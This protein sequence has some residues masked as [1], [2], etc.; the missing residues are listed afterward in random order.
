MTTQHTITPDDLYLFNEGTHA[1]LGN[2]LGA[3][4]AT[5]NG[6]EGVHFAVWAPSACEVHLVGDFNNWD[7]TATPMTPC[8]ASGI[9]EAFVPGLDQG[10]TYKYL[11][12][13][14]LA[15]HEALKADPVGIHTETPP[16]SA[17]KVWTPA[18]QWQDSDWLAARDDDNWHRKPMSI[19]EVHLGSWR[20][21]PEQDNRSLSYRELA[22]QLTEY[23]SW[24]GFTHVELMPIMEHPFD[25]S[26]GYQTTG[27]FAP[28]SRFGSPD[29]FA[30]LVD[31][32]HQAGIGVILD[33]VPSH[34]ATDGHGLS[35]FDGT[36]LYEHADPQQGFH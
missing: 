11:I 2:K 36:H 23:V 21:V 1:N 7:G 28:S 6:R 4:A 19:Y 35:L 13:A 9:W 29:D 18:H 32:L 14:T 16:R 10:A 5:C 3:H 25:G 12:C 26:W 15:G 8:E 30:Y 22:D 31:T 17:S 33:W 24:L 20:R 34:F 27:Y